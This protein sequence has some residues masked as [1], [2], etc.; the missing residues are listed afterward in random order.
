MT[1]GCGVVAQQLLAKRILFQ[2][3]FT[4]LENVCLLSTM[5]YFCLKIFLIFQD[6]FLPVRHLSNADA[7]HKKRLPRRVIKDRQNP[8]TAYSEEEFIQR[9]R[10][11]KECTHTLL[12]ELEPYLPKAQD[13]RG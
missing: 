12:A 6:G 5:K 1:Q 11:S 13:G 4:S 9:Y 3:S 7:A 2:H 10:L 8:F